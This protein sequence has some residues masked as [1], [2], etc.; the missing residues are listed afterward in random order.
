MIVDQK[1]NKGFV[2]VYLIDNDMEGT[3]LATTKKPNWL[4]RTLTFWVMGW[5]WIS[6]QE[7]KK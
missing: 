4:R 1:I 7:L 2:G 3:K 6:V 5:R